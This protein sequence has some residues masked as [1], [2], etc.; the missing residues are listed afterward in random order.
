MNVITRNSVVSLLIITLRLDVND[1]THASSIAIVTNSC[2][3]HLR[4][5]RTGRPRCTVV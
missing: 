2:C 4:V 1:T 3:F 5:F